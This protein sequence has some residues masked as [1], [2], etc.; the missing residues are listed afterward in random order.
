MTV[1]GLVTQESDDSLSR[2]VLSLRE[3][4]PAEVFYRLPED[5]GARLRPLKRSFLARLFG[6]QP[7]L[8]SVY[9]DLRVV[10][11]FSVQEWPDP[12]K[13]LP[14]AYIASNIVVACYDIP[15]IWVHT[16]IGKPDEFRMEV[17]LHREEGEWRLL[18]LRL[19]AEG[20][21]E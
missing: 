3:G 7:E 20:I 12:E 5:K 14:L 18:M 2:I 13:V 21:P 9:P 19:Y 11:S 8:T 15:Y 4:R 16:N 1:V 6:L 10:C 17:F